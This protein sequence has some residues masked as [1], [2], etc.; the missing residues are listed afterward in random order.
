MDLITITRK[1][2]LE[3]TVHLRGHEVTT[4]MSPEEGGLDAGPNPVELLACSVG[5]CVA[6]MLQGY[7]DEKGYTDG[8]VG[9]SLTLELDDDPK[10]IAGVIIDVELPEDFPEGMRDEARRVVEAFPV[11]ETLR[12]PPRVDIDFL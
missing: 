1:D 5:S 8:D 10:R 7:C 2:G 4:D 11:P 12:N 9:V 6:T 3:F